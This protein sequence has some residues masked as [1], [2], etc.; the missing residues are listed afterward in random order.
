MSTTDWSWTLT[1]HVAG[2]SG[3]QVLPGGC[4]APANATPDTILANILPQLEK[5][6]LRGVRYSIVRFTA[7]RIA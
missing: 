7:T 3:E 6:P 2:V 5:G 1:I 4:L